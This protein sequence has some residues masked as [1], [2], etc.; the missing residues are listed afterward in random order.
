MTADVSAGDAAAALVFHD[1]ASWAE[2]RHA[3][4]S[5]QKDVD[6]YVYHVACDMCVEECGRAAL[7]RGLQFKARTRRYCNGKLLVDAL[8]R[9]TQAFSDPRSSALVIGSGTSTLPELVY[10]RLVRVIRHGHAYPS[11]DGR[12]HAH[13]WPCDLRGITE[14]ML[15]EA[16]AAAVG[17]VQ[18]RNRAGGRQGLRCVCAD[19]AGPDF[20][21]QSCSG[22]TDTA[23]TAPPS[24]SANPNAGK[25]D[26]AVDRVCFLQRTCAGH[27]LARAQC[28]QV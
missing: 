17:M 19:V 14:V 21:V 20:T 8:M 9:A 13:S 28:L 16:S 2:A 1:A 22:G 12:Q 6:W 3:A 7:P 5:I 10:D 23:G 15:V 4:A 18:E 25:F 11:K 24:A 27:G 26:I